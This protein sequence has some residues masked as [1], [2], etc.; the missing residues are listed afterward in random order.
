M[1]VQFANT[2]GVP[3]PL[4]KRAFCLASTI[5]PVPEAIEESFNEIAHKRLAFCE[6]PFI[7]G[8]Q[9]CADERFIQS[10]WSNGVIVRSCAQRHCLMGLEASCFTATC[11]QKLSE[12]A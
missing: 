1:P 8:R 6:S 2:I 12:F 11:C 10:L 4:G 7:I 5:I 3:S 9:G